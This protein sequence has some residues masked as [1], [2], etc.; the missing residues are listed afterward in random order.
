MTCPNRSRRSRG[1]RILCI[2]P[3]ATLVVLLVL[4]WSIYNSKGKVHSTQILASNLLISVIDVSVV[5]VLKEK[6]RNLLI[7]VESGYPQQPRQLRVWK[8]SIVV[9]PFICFCSHGLR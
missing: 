9:H 5:C 8:G 6:T 7:G 3:F 1:L 2:L 4:S